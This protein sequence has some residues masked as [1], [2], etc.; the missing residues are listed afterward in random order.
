MSDF[1]AFLYGFCWAWVTIKRL[2]SARSLQQ[3]SPR[4]RTPFWTK[5]SRTFPRTLK[6]T[7]FIFQGLHSM[8]KKPWVYVFFSS[9]TTWAI[10]SWRSF[11]VRVVQSKHRN[12]RTSQHRLQFSRTFKD[13]Q[14]AC[15]P[16]SQRPFLKK[17][18]GQ[19]IK[20]KKQ[21]TCSYKRN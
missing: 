20:L 7:F 13:F 15:E 1:W 17:K 10:L 4:V 21:G 3:I 2:W 6:D 12:S 16:W 9:S 18:I 5:N 8:L 11:C 19:S 14:G